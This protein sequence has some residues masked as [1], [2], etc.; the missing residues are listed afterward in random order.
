MN[1]EASQPG[2]GR[3]EFVRNLGECGLSS[4]PELHKAVEE[5][6]N[7]SGSE[8]TD[9]LVAAGKLTRYQVECILSRRF[10]DLV[11]DNY[12]VL[13][14]LGAG[15]MGTVYK[16]RHRRM[17][18]VV[19]L[20]VLSKEVARQESFAQ[21]FQ[22]EVEVIAQLTHPN[23]VMAFDADE[24]SGGPFLVMEFINGR[25]LSTEVAKTGALSVADAVECI[26]Q[27]ARGL[28]YAHSQGIIHRDI[29]P[30]NILRDASG[31]IKVADL[32]LARIS[33]AEGR[34]ANTSLTQTGGVVGTVD[35][36]PPEQALDS[37]TINH[38]ADI[39]S[40]G[41]TLFY[42]LTGSPPYE[43]STI[44]AVLLKHREAPIPALCA[45][46]PDAPHGLDALFQRMMAKRAQDRPQTMTDVVRELEAL[47]RTAQLSTTRPSGLV[48]DSR[49]ET[50]LSGSTVALEPEQASTTRKSLSITGRVTGRT[51]VLAEPSAAQVDIMRGYLQQLGIAAVSAASSGLDAIA[52]AKQERADV[53]ISA[54]H[55]SDM[56]GVE[57]AHELLADPE[58]VGVGFVLATSEAESDEADALPDSHRVV[59]MM[60]P[61]DPERLAE[62]IAQAIG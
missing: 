48:L 30:G 11:I 24:Y 53:L 34:T 13:D 12:E 57:L 38:R 41:C 16:A 52:L 61:F 54:L 5:A 46:R 60:K 4:L 36:M 10:D 2:I 27:A 29:K 33:G 1:P 49:G 6:A 23:I 17:K 20:K 43:G 15:A 21:R 40:L 9:E 42:L 28:E 62:A 55:L 59:R 26:L 31:T 47:K 18:R 14:R 56:T 58:C 32:G 51:V 50:S 35:Y 8:L 37:T 19:A 3:D 22:R 7:L 45:I 39:Y 25:D 44:L